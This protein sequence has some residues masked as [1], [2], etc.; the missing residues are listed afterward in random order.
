MPDFSS[1]IG[2]LRKPIDDIYSTSSSAI[3]EKMSTIR[4][5]MRMRNLH[6]KLW[7]S[8]KVKTIWN[9]ERP[10]SLSSFFFPVS[11]IRQ[12]SGSNIA[13]KLTSLDDLPDNHNIIFG[14]VGQGKSI[15]LRYLLGKEMKSG[16]RIPV[17]CELRNVE[18]AE[19]T[20]Y[21]TE[22]FSSLMGLSA[23]NAEVFQAFANG[24]KISFLLDG[25]DEIDPK[26]VARLTAEIEDL[27]YRFPLCRIVLTLDRKPIASILPIFT[28]IVF[29]LWIFPIYLHFIRK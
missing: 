18:S 12:E 10:L 22:R 5:A 26:N 27:S 29:G 7:E 14:T 8:Q 25:F 13:V 2:L 4:T 3:Q 6:K 17:F 15:L 20:K 21:L 16:T 28:L 1:A 19:L 24:G 9:T 11:V 23:T